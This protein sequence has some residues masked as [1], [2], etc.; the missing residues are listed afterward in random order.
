MREGDG[1]EATSG[2]HD[3]AVVASVDVMM[4]VGD[5]GPG[6]GDSGQSQTRRVAAA[7]LDPDL[8][9]GVGS[10]PGSPDSAVG[11]PVRRSHHRAGPTDVMAHL[12]PER[13]A[14]VRR[15]LLVLA[16]PAAVALGAGVGSIAVGM[17]EG[18]G[19][20]ILLFSAVVGACVSLAALDWIADRV[21]AWLLAWSARSPHP[22]RNRGAS[23]LA[24]SNPPSI[25]WTACSTEDLIMTVHQFPARYQAKDSEARRAMI[26]QRNRVRSG[27]HV[28]HARRHG[29]TPTR[30][31]RR[32]RVARDSSSAPWRHAHGSPPTC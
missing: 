23:N 26:A 7:A 17:P 20:V 13:Q 28:R 29:P 21:A 15:C 25:R 10:T 27:R 16:V 5:P 1:T 31:G 9:P 14:A 3:E 4:R 12:D 22:G 32:R 6:R 8:G 24:R 19:A 11:G 30:R 2:D 18:P